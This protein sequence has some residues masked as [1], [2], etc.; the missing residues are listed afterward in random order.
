MPLMSS[1]GCW[2]NKTSRNF[3][4][5]SDNDP[6]SCFL[7]CGGNVSLIALQ[8]EK[9]DCHTKFDMNQW[10]GS[11]KP[12]C[13]EKCA[14]TDWLHCGSTAN[15]V[16]SFFETASPKDLNDNRI[17][18]NETGCVSVGCKD[19]ISF[20]VYSCSETLLGICSPVAYKQS[21]CSVTE[22]HFARNDGK[23]HCNNAVD[24]LLS[25]TGRI[26]ECCSLE[27]DQDTYWTGFFRLQKL[28]I[29]VTT[30]EASFTTAENHQ[31]HTSSEEGMISTNTDDQN[32]SKDAL[33]STK[34][35]TM[36]PTYIPAKSMIEEIFV[37]STEP[38]TN[39]VKASMSTAKN[40]TLVSST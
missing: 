15:N 23:R 17:S 39:K 1:K 38:M 4:L 30:N 14:G 22:I 31:L 36:D 12:N 7:A 20:T 13:I 10:K 19:N 18:M 35:R 40:V 26:R 27:L 2:F 37:V 6:G 16:W 3:I 9:C 21:D 34:S 33:V 5:V 24:E 29:D 25:D 28:K 11:L 32:T 8:G